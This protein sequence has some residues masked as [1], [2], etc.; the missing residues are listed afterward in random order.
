[1]PSRAIRKKRRSIKSNKGPNRHDA[2]RPTTA[3]QSASRPR[4][5][6][7]SAGDT[8]GIAA[9]A[10]KELQRSCDVDIWT[11]AFTPNGLL[12]SKILRLTL[13]Y[14]AGVFVFDGSD[15]TTS[16]GQLFTTVRDNVVFEIGVF[17]GGL[18]AERTFLLAGAGEMTK[19]PS[20]IR[21]LLMATSEEPTEKGVRVATRRIATALAGLG[22]ALRS[23]HNEILDLKN[24]IDTR[25]IYVED[26][27]KTYALGDLVRTS[28]MA[29][30]Q[31]WFSGTHPR[32]V[33][34][35]IWFAFSEDATDECYWELVVLGVFRFID[36]ENFTDGNS[37]D[38]VDSIDHV[39]LSSRGVAL[40]NVLRNE[41]WG[42]WMHGGT[43]T[44]REHSCP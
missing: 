11:E 15:L 20:D 5:F 31:A 17:M 27:E 44:Q 30:K 36:S 29:R 28:V 19:V 16:K 26:D 4:V 8:L 34:D 25:E 24:S 41:Y 42:P 12:L 18:G 23:S 14:D 43:A 6:I 13:D 3:I 32:S 1:M 39:A 7:G 37:W 40:L 10:K 38:W 9:F 35:P 22:P 2:Q 33:M 21:G